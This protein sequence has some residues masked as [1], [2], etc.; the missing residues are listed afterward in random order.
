MD[1]RGR[2]GK[3]EYVQDI[4]RIYCLVDFLPCFVVI[5]KLNKQFN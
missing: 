1:V 2:S 5:Y 4:E 3:Q